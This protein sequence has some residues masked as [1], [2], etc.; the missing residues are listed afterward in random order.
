M[1]IFGL[2]PISFSCISHWVIAEL[3]QVVRMRDISNS[4]VS[5]MIGLLQVYTPGLS[6]HPIHGGVEFGH[7]CPTLGD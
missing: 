4:R 1:L 2:D 7:L 3:T 6:R 5:D